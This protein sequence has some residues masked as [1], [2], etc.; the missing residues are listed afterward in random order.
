MAENKK[1]E[2]DYYDDEGTPEEKNEPEVSEEE[3][4][5]REIAELVVRSP[6][7]KYRDMVFCVIGV[8][9]L[10]AI[11][12]FWLLFCHPVVSEAQATGRLMKVELKGMA[13]KTYEGEMVS[14]QYITDTIMRQSN[15][16]KFSIENDSLYFRMVPL[17]NTGKKLTIIYKQYML[18]LPWRGSS[19]YVATGVV[20]E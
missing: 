2:Y 19:K 7:D 3:K 15:D 14:E 4:E 13:F 11:F 12:V 6:R 18:P 9:V 16:F 1:L 20:E 5:D 8:S 10:A 17:Q